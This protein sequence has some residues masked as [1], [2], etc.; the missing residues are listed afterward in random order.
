LIK[1]V[2]ILKSEKKNKLLDDFLADKISLTTFKNSIQIDF[3]I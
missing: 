2:K 1:A 3:K